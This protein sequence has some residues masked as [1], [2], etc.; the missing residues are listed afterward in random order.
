MGECRNNP[1]WMTCNCLIFILNAHF[2]VFLGRVACGQ[3]IP[4]DYAYGS[5]WNILRELVIATSILFIT[6]LACSDYHPQCQEWAGRGECQKNGWMLEN[7][8]RSCGKY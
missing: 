6:L 1:G 7:C 8:K 2:I 5:E 4:G 3:C